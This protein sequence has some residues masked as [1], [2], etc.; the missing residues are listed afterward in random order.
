MPSAGCCTARRR[1]S[2]VAHLQPLYGAFAGIEK[3]TDGFTDSRIAPFRLHQL[4]SL[5]LAATSGN[6][7][8]E[9]RL[10][11]AARLLRQF[12][13]LRGEP[14]QRQRFHDCDVLQT[15]QGG[16]SPAFRFDGRL[17]VRHPLNR[18][19]ELAAAGI[20]ACQQLIPIVHG[21]RP[22]CNATIP[23]VRYSKLTS[24][25]P[26][27]RIMAARFGAL[28]NLRTDSGR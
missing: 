27:L 17:L 4:R 15:I 28:G 11:L 14:A 23:P 16:P 25:K 18:R 8:V 5:H 22:I 13:R 24:V 20:Q 7:R 1:R 12:D 10:A 21:I 19:Q 26:A 6:A 2:K 3:R 9:H